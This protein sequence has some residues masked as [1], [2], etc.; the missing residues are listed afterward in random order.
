M[1]PHAPLAAPHEDPRPLW[2]RYRAATPIM[3]APS[4]LDLAAYAEGRIRGAAKDA[5]EATLARNPRLLAD[6]IAARAAFIGAKT[7][8][9][10]RPGLLDRLGWVAAVCGF[11]LAVWVGFATGEQ[12]ASRDSEAYTLYSTAGDDNA[13]L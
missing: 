12:V 6:V 13:D 5:V 11:C 8:I 2:H 7:P 3:G 1:N 9:Q 10:T 4:T